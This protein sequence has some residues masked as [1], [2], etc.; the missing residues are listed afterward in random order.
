MKGLPT[1][2]PQFEECGLH[3]RVEHHGKS[4]ADGF[5]GVLSSFYANH[6]K[7]PGAR[8]ATAFDLRAAYE[9]EAAKRDFDATVAGTVPVK[10]HFVQ[11]N[12]SEDDPASPF[13]MAKFQQ[14]SPFLMHTYYL[15]ASGGKVYD[16]TYSSSDTFSEVSVDFAMVPRSAKSSGKNPTPAPCPRETNLR[17]LD[18]K[19][20]TMDLKG[21]AVKRPRLASEGA[22]AAYAFDLTLVEG[23]AAEAFARAL[24]RTPG[25]QML[26]KDP[27]KPTSAPMEVGTLGGK[28]T[29]REVRAYGLDDAAGDYVFFKVF[30]A[31]GSSPRVFK[32]AELVEAAVAEPPTVLFLRVEAGGRGP[33]FQAVHV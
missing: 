12:T 21:N 14:T 15:R 30:T 23:T 33:D 22:L 24:L 4:G 10:T 6:I 5:F 7:T 18:A 28:L 16:H 31:F 13:F 2:F 17:K 25:L 29:W 8:V 9:S 27:E 19:F 1:R 26:H 3:F 32:M 11:K 20:A